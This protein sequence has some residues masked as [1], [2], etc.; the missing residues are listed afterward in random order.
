LPEV[1]RQV[2][3]SRCGWLLD[4]Y[5]ERYD[6]RAS[7][8]ISEYYKLPLGCS[9]PIPI[10]IIHARYSKR[11]FFQRG[12]LVVDPLKCPTLAVKEIRLQVMQ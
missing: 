5:G 9:L 6:L 1:S 8:H 11:T 7:F 2:V 10:I 3:D 12:C 4:F